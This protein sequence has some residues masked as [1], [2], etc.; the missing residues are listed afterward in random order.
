MKNNPGL[1]PFKLGTVQNKVNTWSFIQIFDITDLIEEFY[2]LQDQYVRIKNA[3]ENETNIAQSYKKSFYNSYNL[4][5]SFENKIISQINQLN[6]SFHTR[7]K[8]G[9]INGLGSIIKS[10]TGNLDQED[11]E[12][13]ERAIK[14][15]S[16][17]QNKIKTI[18]QDQI[19]LL[20][21]SIQTFQSNIQNLTSNQILLKQRIDQIEELL[22]TLES[23]SIG[24]YYYLYVEM[25]ISQIVTEFQIIYDV[26]ERLEVAI[27]FSKLNTFHNSII[28]SKDLL[29]EIESISKYLTGNELPFEPKIEN[30]LL[31]EKIMEIK[32]YSK[33]NQIIFI[34]EIPI[35]EKESYNYFHLYTLP[36]FQNESF[37]LI[38]PQSKYLIMNE[39]NYFFFD[40]PCK[41]IIPE[42]FICHETN[43]VKATEDSPCEI[44]LLKFA[45]NLSNCHVVPVRI[46]DVKVQKLELNRWIVLTPEVTVAVQK[47]GKNR[48]NI[49]LKGS[50][51]LELNP[52]CEIR[53]K[54]ILIRNFESAK[55]KF[56]NIVLPK[57]NFA[58]P[59]YKTIT[60]F[61]PLKLDN[62]NLNEISAVKSA[63]EINK[64]NINSI[65][66]ETINFDNINGWTILIYIL[67]LLILLFVLYKFYSQRCLPKKTEA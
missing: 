28:E 8:R 12:K 19:S 61:K 43:P 36:V 52:A 37:Q 45:N 11:A 9:L 5:Q 42:E 63:L 33:G 20:E 55:R 14:T 38:I 48:E 27:T 13:Y 64:Q 58:H 35:V 39:Q 30:L 66:D 50:Y 22:H 31:F 41:E 44:Q 24:T 60:D 1:L 34:I 6:P 59:V 49:P 54:D 57:I 56:K 46:E 47:C 2:D 65:K 51:L 67:I 17:N 21:K 4:A 3:F 25:V 32:S 18:V 7:P 15:L 26:L 16:N 10:I 40:T 29:T 53:I 23:E 62:I